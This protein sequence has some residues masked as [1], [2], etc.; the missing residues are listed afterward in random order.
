[1][2]QVWKNIVH[3]YLYTTFIHLSSMTPMPTSRE[4]HSCGLVANLTQGPEVIVAG[5]ESGEDYT[6][7][8]DIYS[9][10]ADSWRPGN[11]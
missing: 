5:G 8:V 3:D 2:G 11:L 9:V 4:G 10:D 6:D 1:M 7:G